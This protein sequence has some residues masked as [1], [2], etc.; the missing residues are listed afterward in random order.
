MHML[1][2]SRPS[3]AAT[4]PSQQSVNAPKDVWDAS[5]YS[6]TAETYQHSVCQALVDR[7]LFFGL[8]LLSAYFVPASDIDVKDIA[9]EN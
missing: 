5:D 3:S 9:G 7:D 4:S 1:S 8:Y 2:P 6:S